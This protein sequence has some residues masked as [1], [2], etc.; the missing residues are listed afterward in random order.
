MLTAVADI[1]AR[2]R[3]R[4]APP[5]RAYLERVARMADR[6]RGADHMG[7]ANV[8]H[9]F[10]ALPAGDKLRVVVE[11]APHLGIVTAYNDMLFLLGAARTQQI[12]QTDCLSL[13]GLDRVAPGAMRLTAPAGLDSTSARSEG[14]GSA[15]LLGDPPLG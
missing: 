14:R 3:E 6:P 9:A 5:R 1:T 4:S 15:A 13:I 2:I 10:A 8:A 12:G 11:R 7:C